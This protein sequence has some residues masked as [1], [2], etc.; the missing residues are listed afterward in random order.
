MPKEEATEDSLGGFIV[1]ETEGDIF[2]APEDSILIREYTLSSRYRPTR[3]C[4][5]GISSEGLLR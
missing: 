2:D 4:T 1:T 5:S 3:F